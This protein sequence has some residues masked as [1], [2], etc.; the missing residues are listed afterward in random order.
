MYLNL[1]TQILYGK[2]K[3]IKEKK[4]RKIHINPFYIVTGIVLVLGTNV[5]YLAYQKYQKYQQEQDIKLELYKIEQE[6]K[7]AAQKNAALRK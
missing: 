2:W 5:S 1:K 3:P 7:N 6:K 4:E